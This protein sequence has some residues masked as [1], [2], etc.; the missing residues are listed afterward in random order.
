MSTTSV[1]PVDA[2]GSSAFTR[3]EDGIRRAYRAEVRKLSSQI[4]IRV[5]ALLCL[6]V[7]FIFAALLKVQSGAPADTLYGVWVHSSGFAVSLVV[8]AS[9]ATWGVPLIAGAVAG[10]IFSSEDRYGTWKLVLTRS[11]TRS[12]VFVGKLLAAATFVVGLQ[13]LTGL[14][15]MAA[16][17]LLVGAQ[18]LVNLNGT[19]FSPGHS[20]LLVFLSWLTLIPPAIA[21]TA[22]AVLLSIAT[23]NGILGV[24]APFALALAMQLLLLVGTGIWS[25]LLLI[26]AAVFA[27]HGLF[28]V[29]AY[30]GP[31]LVGVAVSVIWTVVCIDVSWALLRRRDFAGTPV[32]RRQGWGG[33]VRVVV[34]ITAAVALIA[35]AGNWGPAGVTAKR[36]RTDLTPAFNQLTVLQQRELGRHVPAGAKL[37]LVLP[38]C[39]RRGSVPYG[40]GEWICTIYVQTP[41]PGALPSQPTAVAYDVSVNWDGCYKAQSPPAFIGQQMMRDAH[42]HNVV[43]P[44]YTIYGCFDPL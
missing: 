33:P 15:S 24:I 19:L 13:L 44:L 35:I 25:H 31:L 10:D 16:G 42:G 5:V 20:A 26:G 36:L 28:N 40:P 37:T 11:C 2:P 14:A 8:L 1:L 39:N 41:S 3:P 17:V 18:S 22:V 30:L 38:T 9:A 23:R 29:H 4:V 12:D 27:W 34:A 7:P 21:F 32:S 43:N 6:A